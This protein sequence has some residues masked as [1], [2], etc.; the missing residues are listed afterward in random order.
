MLRLRSQFRWAGDR[1]AFDPSLSIV[2]TLAL[3]V[4]GCGGRADHAPT[5][6]A[7]V[8]APPQPHFRSALAAPSTELEADGI[9]VQRAPL[10]ERTRIPVDSSEPFSPNYGAPSR[11][12]RSADANRRLTIADAP[13]SH[14][15]SADHGILN[16]SVNSEYIAFSDTASARARVSVRDLPDDLPPDFRER[17]IVTNALR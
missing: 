13:K 9:P 11:P 15:Q 2:L 14:V 17:L 1:F 5:A 12:E 16:T 8:I 10:I 3:L 7:R 4:A 6:D